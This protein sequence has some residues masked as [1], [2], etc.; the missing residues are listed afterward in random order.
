MMLACSAVLAALGLV[1]AYVLYEAKNDELVY[2]CRLFLLGNE[3]N[4]PTF[5]A[6]GQLLVCAL[7]LTVIVAQQSYLVNRWRLY[8]V[9]LTIIFFLMSF[10]EA[11]AIHEK[12]IDIIRDTF[13][14]TGWFYLGWVIPGL[15]FVTVFALTYIRFLLALPRP[16]AWLFMVSGAVYV[17][18]AVGFEML[19]GEY[20]ELHGMQN[21]TFHVLVTIGETLEM[22]GLS[23]FAYTLVHYWHASTEPSTSDSAELPR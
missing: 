14:T 12:L 21:F 3:R 23:M 16:I 6:F 9:G 13:H 20:A 7:L 22:V 10:D 2:V 5:F 1:A 4:L 15:L 11:A 8:W 19:K 17:G 18:G